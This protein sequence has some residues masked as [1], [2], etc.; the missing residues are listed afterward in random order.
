M[1]LS[2]KEIRKTYMKYRVGVDKWRQN[3]TDQQVLYVIFSKV[4]D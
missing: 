2:T 1:S 3:E 4:I